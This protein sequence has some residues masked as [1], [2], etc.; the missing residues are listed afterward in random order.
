MLVVLLNRLLVISG[1]I[2]VGRN[3]NF[4]E[5]NPANPMIKLLIGGALPRHTLFPSA[6]FMAPMEENLDS[7]VNGGVPVTLDG[8]VLPVGAEVVLNVEL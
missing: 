1:D 7:R 5:R 4:L 8:E 2:E 6:L 3:H